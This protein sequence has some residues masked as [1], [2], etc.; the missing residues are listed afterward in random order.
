MLLVVRSCSLLVVGVVAWS[1]LF[2]GVDSLLI[3]PGPVRLM[4]LLTG[5]VLLV[6]GVIRHL[7][8]AAKFDPSLV[9]MALRA[10]R[11]MPELDQRLASAVDFTTSGATDRNPMAASSVEWVRT[12]L[13]GRDLGGLVNPL[14]ARRAG[15]LSLAVVGLLLCFVLLSPSGASIGF[16]RMLLPFGSAKWPA[17]TALASLMGDRLVHPRGVPLALS[18]HL[19]LGDPESV[20]VTADYVL[21]DDDR[22]VRERSVV[23]ASQSGGVFEQLVETDGDSIEV[24]FRTFDTETDPILIQ[25]IDPPEIRSATLVV[26]PPAYALDAME[27]IELDLGGGIDRRATPEA[28]FM[29]GSPASMRLV[30]GKPLPTGDPEWIRR[31]F[32]DLAEGARFTRIDELTW[33]LDFRLDRSVGSTLRLEDEHGIRN[34]EEISY[35]FQVVPDRPPSAAILDPE[36]DETVLSDAI[37]PIR[38]EIRD[39]LAV[40][41][42]SLE[43]SRPG[44]P[45]SAESSRPVETIE[46]PGGSPVVLIDHELD[47]SKQSAAPGDVFEVVVIG[48]DIFEL[49]G[50]RHEEA[51]SAVRRLVVI[52]DRDFTESIRNQL[53][54]VRRSAI[55]VESMQQ[56]ARERALAG[57]LRVSEEQ[58]RIGERIAVAEEA[59]QEMERR[60]DRNRLDDPMLRE[61][62]DQSE[63]LLEAAGRASSRAGSSLEALESSRESRGS[64]EGA[65]APESGADP[66][67][68][69]GGSSDSES[70]SESTEGSPSDSPGGDGDV[71]DP[72]LREALRNQDGVRDELEDLIALLDRDEDAWVVTREVESMLEEA[73]E[74]LA[75]TGETGART[76]GRARGDLSE[77]ERSEID[78]IADRQRD[79]ARRTDELADDLRD[80]SRVLEETD[81]RRSESLQSA[82]RRAERS[83]LA[84]L[85]EEAAEQVGENR[86]ANA[87]QTQQATVETLERMLEDLQEDRRARA[88]QLVRQ[89]ASL[90]ESIQRLVRVN[91]DELIALARIPDPSDDGF[92]VAVESR[93]TALIRFVRNTEGVA[94]EARATGQTGQRIARAIDRAAEELGIAVGA[95]RA[96]EPDLENA[97]FRLEASLTELRTA[98]ELAETAAEEAA[99]EAEDRR[100]EEL[101]RAYR[102]LAEREVGIRTGTDAI[103]PSRDDPLTRRDLVKARRLAIEQESIRLD[104]NSLRGEH[105]ELDDSI[106]F[107][108]M[109]TLIDGWTRESGSALQAGEVDD[110]LVDRQDLVIEGLIGLADALA[111]DE[112]GDE[113]PFEQNQQQ[114]GGQSG[115]SGQMGQQEGL[116]P[117]VAELKLLRGMQD[118]VY[119]RTRRLSERIDAGDI[120][121]GRIESAL[122][123]L[124]A[125]QEELHQLGLGLIES[126]QESSGLPRPTPDIVSPAETNELGDSDR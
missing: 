63:D 57:G 117:P 104:L 80:R 76:M 94:A 123:E 73:R 110:E 72:D 35:G 29:E 86:M 74:L 101:V 39:D 1:L 81:P 99:E 6:T 100:R 51:R 89:L 42:A 124:G 21:R 3:L 10:E 14:P 61:I 30:L 85:M 41:Q 11:L 27:T 107:E 46:S 19:T 97:G 96:T 34:T 28:A 65:T 109:H 17:T 87:Q 115:Q 90:V 7:L 113:S 16:Q 12:R 43:I 68:A 48:R 106:L 122:R 84:D 32:G 71:E 95:L 91:E 108:R 2:I 5:L 55:R 56:E 69:S 70:N 18:A 75:D 4:L 31:T 60:I 36:M 67:S 20:R 66:G 116:V 105:P 59:I 83:E 25:V 102:T 77:D 22:I 120:E 40:M 23:L 38:G 79:A 112:S 119:R 98:L 103:L 49:D 44:P 111:E 53:A 47:L 13:E 118:Q 52:D 33:S 126:M 54:S 24:V 64:G 50:R 88:E 45:G 26:D 62:L 121:P 93:S 15:A 82:A 8:P 114:D 37:I 58:G 125:M 78:R 92:A 9:R